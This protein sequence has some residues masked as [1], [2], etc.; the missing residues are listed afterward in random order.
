MKKLVGAVLVTALLAATGCAAV[1]QGLE[2]EQ[3]AAQAKSEM[4]KAKAKNYLW[5]DT[6]KILGKAKKAAKKDDWTTAVKLATK[7]RDQAIMAQKQ[8]DEQ[9]SA[10]AVF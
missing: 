3:I 2:Y 8:A 10:K 7:A 9:A 1:K 6:K 4:A 5:R